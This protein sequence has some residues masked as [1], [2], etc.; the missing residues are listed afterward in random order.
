LSEP[1]EQD[2]TFIFRKTSSSILDTNVDVYF[3]AKAKFWHI[4]CGCSRHG[5]IL[6]QIFT[7]TQ[8][9][10]TEVLFRGLCDRSSEFEC[11]SSLLFKFGELDRVGKEVDDL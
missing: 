4:Y 8:E 2:F 7:W 3:V 9:S 10:N 11:D 6:G 5:N 1:L